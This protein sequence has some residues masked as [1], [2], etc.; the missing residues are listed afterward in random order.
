M[1]AI[2][3][4]RRQ[5]LLQSK[6]S[7]TIRFISPAQHV[8]SLAHQVSK[9]SCVAPQELRECTRGINWPSGNSSRVSIFIYAKLDNFRTK[10]NRLNS[11]ELELDD[12][13]KFCLFFIW[14]WG[15]ALCL[16]L[17]TILGIEEWGIE[18]ECS[19]DYDDVR[20]RGNLDRRVTIFWKKWRWKVPK[21]AGKEF[22]PFSVLHV[23]VELV[24]TERRL[25][26]VV[27]LL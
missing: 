8:P 6:A 13:K 19:F 14:L 26:V 11:E 10:L 2:W 4:K 12:K 23:C 22:Q 7:F 21:K 1:I 27:S 25:T 24:T 17:F 9:G 15:V 20:K 18:A 3:I 16:P 5:R